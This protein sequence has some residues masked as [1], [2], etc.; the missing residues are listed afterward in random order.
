MNPKIDKM[1]AAMGGID[2]AYLEEA[3]NY[4]PKV[5]GRVFQRKKA[6]RFPKLSAAC[7]A[8]LLV[9][10]LSATAIAVSRMPLSWRA[11]FHSS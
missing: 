7:V 9:F 8:L 6:V 5:N 1:S 10:G 3:L 4:V 2:T 11:I